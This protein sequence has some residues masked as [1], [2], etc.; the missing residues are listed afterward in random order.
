MTDCKDLAF[1]RLD[2]RIRLELA[3]AAE[4]YASHVDIDAR[5]QAIQAAEKGDNCDGLAI[6]DS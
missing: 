3:K 2:A 4:A 5:L 1:A 6:E